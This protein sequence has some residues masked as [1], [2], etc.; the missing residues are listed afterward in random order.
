MKAHVLHFLP[1]A[2]VGSALAPTPVSAQSFEIGQ[3]VIA[4]GDLDLGSRSG[5]ARLDSRIREAV[6]AA[7][8]SV[9]AIDHAGHN[10]VRT[11][12]YEVLALGRAHRNTL[13][14]QHRELKKAE[15]S[16]RE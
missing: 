6:E 15:L 5:V 12:R 7:C 13:V 8:G 14:A 9:S 3:V 4:Y 16:S 11:C 10:A 2:L 1:A